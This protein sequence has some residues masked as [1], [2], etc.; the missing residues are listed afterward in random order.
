MLAHEEAAEHYARALEVLD[1]FAAG[2]A[3]AALRAAAGARRGAGPRRRARA[4]AAGV[5]RGGRAGRAARRQRRLARA[6]IGASRRYVQQP[7]VVDD[8]LIELLE[9]ALASDR[10]RAHRDA[11]AAAG[12]LV[13]GALLLARARPDGGA[14]RGGERALAELGRSGG[15][16]LRL[17]RAP[18]GAVGRRRTCRTAGRASTEML[19]LRA[20]GG[21][22]RARAAGAR[23]AGGRPARARRRD[24]VDAQMEAFAAGAERLRQPLYHVAGDGLAGDAGAAGRAARRRR[25]AGRRGAGG[26]R[27]GETV[28][29]PQY[30]AIQLLAIRREQ[31]RIGRARGR[32]RASW[33]TTNPERPAW[34]AALASCCGRPAGRRRPRRSSTAGRGHDF[35]DVPHDG[36]W[37]TDDDAADRRLR[38]AR[39]R[40]T[41]P[42]SSTS[43]AARTRRPTS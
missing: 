21:R 1:R 20:R 19:T 29:A 15:P 18:A 30:Y 10:R 27:A 13:R 38:R 31:G 42:R 36:D 23:L 28:T 34:R 32:P 12:A 41:A 3:A 5:P 8:E 14:E 39:R 40:A 2:R 11:G 9:R 37:M 24:A 25:G 33:S 22:P 35:A 26:R 16:G 43:A 4:G 17:R 7:G 6:A